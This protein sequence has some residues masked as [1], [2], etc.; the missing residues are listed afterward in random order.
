MSVTVGQAHA[1][2]QVTPGAGLVEAAIAVADDYRADVLAV[3]P[4]ESGE[5]PLSRLLFCAD[6]QI[7][8]RV[9]GRLM[10][11]IQIIYEHPAAMDAFDGGADALDRLPAEFGVGGQCGDAGD[12]APFRDDA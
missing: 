10:P 1:A 8:Q 2:G 12:A 9:G 6:A 3:E 5:C 11:I 7:D 4:D